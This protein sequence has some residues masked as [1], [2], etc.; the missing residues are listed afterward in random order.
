VVDSV[1]DKG[2]VF[3]VTIPRLQVKNIN[4]DI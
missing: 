3:T 1:P 2:S 4:S